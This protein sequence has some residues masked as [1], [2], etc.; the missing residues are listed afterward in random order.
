MKMVMMMMSNMIIYFE[1]NLVVNLN[2]M[3]M[4]VIIIEN[5]NHTIGGQLKVFL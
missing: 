4:I 2:R 3:K 5:S 1:S